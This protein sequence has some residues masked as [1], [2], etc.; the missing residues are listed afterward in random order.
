MERRRCDQCEYYKEPDLYGT[1]RCRLKLPVTTSSNGGVFVLP[2][3][4]ADGY[5][6]DW[7]PEWLDNPVLAVAWS[8]FKLAHKLITSGEKDG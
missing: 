6:A 5:C 1:P 3:I 8:E 4:E 7:E 2:T